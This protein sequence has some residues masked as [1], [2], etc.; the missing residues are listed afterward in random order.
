MTLTYGVH[1][2]HDSGRTDS[3]LGPLPDLN[4][5]GAGLGEKIRNPNLNFA[6]QA[7]FVWDAGGNGKTVIRGGGG[8]F[9]E[10]SFWNN[11]LLDSP[12]R[13]T[14]GIFPDAPEVCSGGVANAVQ[15]ADQSRRGG[16]VDCGRGCYGGAKRSTGVL[17][18]QPTFCGGT[19][20]TVAPQILALSSAY[21]AAAATRCWEPAEWQLRWHDAVGAESQ[22]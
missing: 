21:Q 9:Y 11:T 20:S 13:L 18:A 19:I 8:L 2:V 14:K 3:G 6:P 12:S 16:A 4:Q 1:Y 22:L 17:Q 10:N 7:G 5:W 15:L